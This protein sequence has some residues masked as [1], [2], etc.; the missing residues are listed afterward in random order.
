MT[1]TTTEDQTLKQYLLGRLTPESLS[2]VEARVFSDDR[3]FWEHL[4][5]VEEDLINDYAR[6]TLPD[7]EQ[8]DF[9]QRFLVTGERRGRVEFA[10]AL[11]EYVADKQ[12]APEYVWG[13][14]RRPVATPAWAAVAA[15]L[16]VL[17]LAGAVWQRA[18]REPAP[19]SVITIAL[20]P[21]L[22]RDTGQSLP[23]VQISAADQLVRLQFDP[24]SDAYTVYR[25]TLYDVAGAEIWS[26]ARLTPGSPAGAGALVLPLPSA[27]LADGDYYLRLDGL[28]PDGQAVP[29]HRYNF[30]VL[31][32][33]DRQVGVGRD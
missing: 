11:H 22:T 27:I 33:L 2:R 7:D 29:L 13:W 28:S 8:D 30:R 12:A 21:S 5:L 20:T 9:E 23:R 16:V 17:V 10:R 31:R 4:C 18:G 19:A 1:E 14:L 26:Q 32:T 25:A 15:A 6:G 3:I 24:G